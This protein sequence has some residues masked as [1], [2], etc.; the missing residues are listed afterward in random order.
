LEGLNG[1]EVG[2][3][4][5][6]FAGNPIGDIGFINEEV[7]K[8]VETCA[9][10][11]DVI[12]EF[13]S[14]ADEPVSPFKG[15]YK[16]LS[17]GIIQLCCDRRLDFALQVV[18]SG[19]INSGHLAKATNDIRSAVVARNERRNRLRR[20]G[21]GRKTHVPIA[22][23]FSEDRTFTTSRKKRRSA[24]SGTSPHTLTSSRKSWKSLTLLGFRV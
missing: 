11:L 22:L 20:L 9:K 3:K 8:R 1:L 13:A 24:S 16:Y 7:G 5:I 4:G 10:R 21:R 15:F 14:T 6:T 12:K 23:S 19:W 17:L 2:R 18:P